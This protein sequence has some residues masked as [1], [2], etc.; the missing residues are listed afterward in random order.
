MEKAQRKALGL[1]DAIEKAGLIA[2]G[3]SE[4]DVEED[5]RELAARDFGVEKHWHRRIVRSGPNSI[6]TAGDYP[7]VRIIEDNDIVYLDLG[8]V[9]EG[10]EADIGRSY[11]L[12]TD[13]RKQA[14]VADLPRVFETVQAYYRAHPHITGAELYA[15]AEKAACER[16]WLFGGEIAGHIISEFAHSQIPGDKALNRIG[17]QNSKAMSDPDD[18]GRPRH[19]ILEIHLVA[20]DRSFGGFYERLL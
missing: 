20:P 4:K 8:P 14:L 2:A 16:G 11:A 15:F 3:R 10:W 13:R 1:F 19:W 5:I 6:T 17:P 12:G 7:P 18:L 9:F